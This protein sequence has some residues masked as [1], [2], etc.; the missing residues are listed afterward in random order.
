LLK[1]FVWQKHTQC[2]K[3]WTILKDLLQVELS[4]LAHHHEAQQLSLNVQKH[5]WIN[6]VDKNELRPIITKVIESLAPPVK[7]PHGPSTP[8]PRPDISSLT[9]A[10]QENFLA[11]YK[12]L[13]IHLIYIDSPDDMQ[14]AMEEKLRER[15]ATG[16]WDEWPSEEIDSLIS[17]LW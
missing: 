11:A 5:I 15:I 2:G 12:Q 3:L 10:Y 14:W 4:L 17:Q 6:D 13:Q 8:R 16:N 7:A 1:H 9:P